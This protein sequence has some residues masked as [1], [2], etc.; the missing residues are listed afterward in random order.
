MSEQLHHEVAALGRRTHIAFSTVR[1]YDSEG[2]HNRV[3]REGRKQEL[4]SPMLTVAEAEILL[5]HYPNSE[6]SLKKGGTMTTVVCGRRFTLAVP[7]A[8]AVGVRVDEG[9]YVPPVHKVFTRQPKA[10]AEPPVDDLPEDG[11]PPEGYDG[12]TDGPMEPLFEMLAAQ[13]MEVESVILKE[14][15]IKT[16]D[17]VEVLKS[18][19]LQKIKGIGAKRA[20]SILRACGVESA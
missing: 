19:G 1:K 4:T 18:A 2:G 6:F 10:T 15:G 11:T 20:E 13:G 9:D 14:A 12:P 3:V 8:I 17:D 5:Q 16:F 7:V